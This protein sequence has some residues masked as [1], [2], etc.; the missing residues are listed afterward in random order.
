MKAEKL[1]GHILQN[2]KIVH[3]FRDARRIEKVP[4]G[5]R[6]WSSFSGSTYVP[7]DGLTVLV[8]KR[9]VLDYMGTTTT[10]TLR[11][12]ETERQEPLFLFTH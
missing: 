4:S 1:S 11:I 2:G 10:D 7:G 6:V 9:T 3:S 8:L 5:I 12:Q